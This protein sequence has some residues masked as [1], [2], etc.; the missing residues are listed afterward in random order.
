[1]YKTLRALICGALLCLSYGVQAQNIGNSPYSRYGLGEVN[2]NVGNIRNAGMANTG[3]G[4]GNS[5]QVST[6]NPALLYYNSAT[7]FEIGVAGQVKTLKNS[8]QSQTDGN[9]NLSA[10]TLSV[11]VSK[12][13]TSALSLRPYSNVDYDIRSRSSIQQDTIWT[14][15]TGDGGISELYFGHGVRITPGLTIGVSASYLFGSITKESITTIQNA[16]IDKSLITEQVAYTEKTRYN[17][18]LFRTGA[19]YRKKLK[20]KLY[21]SAGAVYSLKADLSAERNAGYERRTVFG[22]VKEANLYADSAKS[23]VN[24][25]SSLGI[26]FSMDNGSNFTIAADYQSQQWS[27][28]RNFNGEQELAD[29]YRASVG[30]ELTPNPNSIGNYFERVTYRGGLYYGNSPYKINNEQVTDKGLTLGLSLPLGRSTVYD[31]YQL[32][33]SMAFGSRGTTDKGLVQENYFQFMVGVTVNS[34]W[35]I[36]RRLE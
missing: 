5:F 9:A 36:K 30:A 14:W 1:M 2:Y 13:W 19:S 16:G 20:D 10:V 17:D 32:N 28:F 22:V 23:K 31:M 11:P 29:S 12:R 4:A 34:R 21:L 7:T 25:P 3:I 33:T 8:Q 27:K 35:F 26:G 15:Y 6:S 24:I 18:L